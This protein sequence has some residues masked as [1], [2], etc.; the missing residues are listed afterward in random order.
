MKDNNLAKQIDTFGEDHI[1]SSTNTP[2]R[3]DAFEISD[4]EKIAIIEKD[5]KS[6]LHTLGLDLTDDSLK[7]TPK[8]VAKA[9]VN[10]I[11]GGLN[12]ANKPVASTFDNKYKYKEMKKEK[13]K[14]KENEK[15][16]KKEKEQRKVK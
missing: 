9:S 1:G 14:E 2:L 3:I 11:F 7:G 16:K 4:E 15:G 6:I 13:A 12:P 10:E 8:R 5:M